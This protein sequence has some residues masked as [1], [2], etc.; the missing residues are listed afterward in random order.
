MREIE[1][2]EGINRKLNWLTSNTGDIQALKFI[3][4]YLIQNLCYKLS[5]K[6]ILQAN[7]FY[8]IIINFF[9]KLANNI[10]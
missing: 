5:T 2:K 9:A 3:I 8:K 4:A 1:K 7:F 6:F 10:F